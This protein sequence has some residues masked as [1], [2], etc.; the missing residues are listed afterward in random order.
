VF[1]DSAFEFADQ[2]SGK[3]TGEIGVDAILDRGD[4]QLGQPADGGLGE[5]LVRELFEGRRATTPVLP[6]ARWTQRRD[7]YR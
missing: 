7:P 2:F 6:R 1:A 3:T 5:G 4:P